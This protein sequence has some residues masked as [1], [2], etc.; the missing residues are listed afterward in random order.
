MAQG[1]LS[2]AWTNSV[3]TTC[4]DSSLIS[5][6]WRLTDWTFIRKD[7]GHRV[8]RPLFFNRFD[9]L[10]ND[11]TGPLHQDSIANAYIFTGDFIGIV[12]PSGAGKTTLVDV[13]L[14]LLYP[15]KGRFI[16]DGEEVNPSF[17]RDLFVYVPQEQFFLDDS[18]AK[19]IMFDPSAESFE[20]VDFERL[21]S[22]ASRANVLEVIEHLED[23]DDVQEVYTNGEWPE[24]V[25]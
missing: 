25:D 10:R 8:G 1:L 9:D 12:G 13:L 24:E 15:S 4:N 21:I 5:L 14:G 20:T 23:D 22:A 2:L 11:V 16:V 19:N 3:W 18:V 6:G 17:L 7:K